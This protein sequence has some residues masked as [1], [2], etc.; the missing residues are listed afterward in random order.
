MTTDDERTYPPKRSS[1]IPSTVDERRTV[2]NQTERPTLTRVGVLRNTFEATAGEQSKE[3]QSK[4]L[5]TISTGLTKQRR[6][7][8]EAQDQVNK[9]WARRPVRY[10][11]TF[12]V[13]FEGIY[14][15][16]NYEVGFVFFR[17]EG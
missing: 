5:G 14:L 8:F 2:V 11:I 6:E 17:I 7:L 12:F 4:Y 9:E 15:F 13:R 3:D 10:P 16:R 1:S